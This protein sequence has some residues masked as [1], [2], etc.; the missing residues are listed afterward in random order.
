MTK[1]NMH[2]AL[3][4]VRNPWGWSDED[5]RAARLML[6]DAYEV[7][8]RKKQPT[9]SKLHEATSEVRKQPVVIVSGVQAGK[10]W[11]ID[12]FAE[13]LKRAEAERSNLCFEVKALAEIG[14]VMYPGHKLDTVAFGEWRDYLSKPLTIEEFK[15]SSNPK[16]KPYFR[17]F[18][19]GRKWKF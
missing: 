12:A 19:R 2:W 17:Q 6:A 8:E 14:Q 1:R 3:H 16:N 13:A 15:K 7:L 18:E 5:Q 4:V 10:S 9:V 11:V